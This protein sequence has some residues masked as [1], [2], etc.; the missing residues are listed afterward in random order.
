M[1]AAVLQQVC[2]AA[3]VLVADSLKG[4]LLIAFNISSPAHGWTWPVFEIPRNEAPK[5][6]YWH[7][8]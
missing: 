8:E 5:L 6:L 1:D 4:R 3:G 2:V 7:Y